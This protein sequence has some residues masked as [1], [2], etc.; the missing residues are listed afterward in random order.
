MY[1]YV[2]IKYTG[3]LELKLQIV[4]KKKIC[5]YLT[6]FKFYNLFKNYQY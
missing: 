2:Y 1:N 5:L 6:F 4:Y 3:F